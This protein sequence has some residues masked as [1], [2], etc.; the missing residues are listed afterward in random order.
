MDL[1]HVGAIWLHTVAF[2]IAWGYYGILGRMILPALARS[3]DRE[4]QAA[5]IGAIERR[6]LPLIL[7]SLI[8][9]GATGAYLLVADP[10]YEGLGLVFAS[11]WTTLMLVKH[12]LVVALIAAAA[13]VDLFA[14]RLAQAASEPIREAARRWLAL[15]AEGATAIGA[16]IALLTAA[17]QVAS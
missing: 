16:L 7:F 13:A 2:V 10:R 4:G 12:G 1:L 11:T 5:A 15:S 17:A 8:L 3:L 6:A 14:R 9:F